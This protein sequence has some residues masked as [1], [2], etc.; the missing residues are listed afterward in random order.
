MKPVLILPM[1]SALR[2]RCK[3]SEPLSQL[4]S[5]PSLL[6]LQSLARL[7]YKEYIFIISLLYFAVSKRS[8]NVTFSGA[9]NTS[10]L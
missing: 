6:Q 4:Q 5:E 8:I 9:C 2:A 10:R 3:S 7:E 1:A